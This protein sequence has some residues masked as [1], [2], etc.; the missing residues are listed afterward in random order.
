[1]T[2]HLTNKHALVN[3]A[4]CRLLLYAQCSKRHLTPSS[5]CFRP[6][7]AR[8]VGENAATASNHPFRY[9]PALLVD[10]QEN[11]FRRGLGA[12]DNRFG[13]LMY[14]RGNPAFLGEHFAS[15]DPAHI[16][17]WL[18]AMAAGFDSLPLQDLA[19]WRAPSRLTRTPTPIAPV[20]L[21][22]QAKLP[23]SMTPVPEMV[24][25]IGTPILASVRVVASS[26]PRR[27]RAP[28][29]Q[30][31]APLDVAEAHSLRSPQ[32]PVAGAKGKKQDE[33]KVRANQSQQDRDRRQSVCLCSRS[34]E[35][36]DEGHRVQFIGDDHPA[37]V[38]DG[39][40]EH[41]CGKN[42]AGG[43]A[44]SRRD[45]DARQDRG[46]ADGADEGSLDDP[47]SRQTTAESPR[48]FGCHCA[49]RERTLSILGSV[50]AWVF[51]PRIFERSS[52]ATI[53]ASAPSRMIVGRMN[54]MSSVRTSFLPVV[55]KAA[56]TYG[57]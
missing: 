43:A 48:P 57:S 38:S 47:R 49:G 29:R 16:A 30:T 14:R 53:D 45:G 27:M 46:E 56:P 18:E 23:P 6:I 54:I 1:M 26:S 3:F 28:M 12:K 10:L 31:M 25:R 13:R 51:P 44:P 22:I 15:R 24:R 34:Y 19:T 32:R 17:R 11:M 52:S 41:Q 35:T 40:R 7:R 5:A 4:R 39:D 2:E 42:G 20:V 37:V 36:S 8:P 21:L 33:H 55:P 50:S 9:A